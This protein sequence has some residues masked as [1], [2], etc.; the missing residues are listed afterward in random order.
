MVLGFQCDEITDV[1]LTHLH[2]RSLRW[3]VCVLM[4]KQVNSL[5]SPLFKNAKYWSVTKTTGNGQPT[6][7]SRREKASFSK[8]KPYIQLKLQDNLSLLE[9]INTTK[10]FSHYDEF[11][12]R[13]LCLLMVIQKNK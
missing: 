9:I 1:L 4:K 13:S 3:S 11:G 8:R 12:Y 7:N 2:F 6:P 5:R 10:V